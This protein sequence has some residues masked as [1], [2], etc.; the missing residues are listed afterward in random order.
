MTVEAL[1]LWR[2]LQLLWFQCVMLKDDDELELNSLAGEGLP[3]SLA[4]IG[5]FLWDNERFLIAVEQAI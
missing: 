1:I 2:F 3:L 4:E 5:L